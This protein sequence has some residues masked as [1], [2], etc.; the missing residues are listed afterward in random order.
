MLDLEVIDDR[1]AAITALDPTR[2]RILGRLVEPGSATTVARDLGLTRQKANY[3]LR[4]LESHG[5]VQLVEERP[6]RGVTERIVQSTARAYLIAPDALGA[7]VGDPSRVDL[8]SSRYLL[9]LAA[10]LV[11]EVLELARGAERAG[12]PLATLAIDTDVRFR[13]AADRAA[14]TEELA[15][16][17]AGL[18]A[19][20]HD[21]AAPRGRWHRVVVAS[22]P[23]PNPIP[24]THARRSKDEGAP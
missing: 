4:A 15:G 3:H 23:N 13:N 10:R 8:L 2:A 7:E 5:L 17:V 18:A 9:A 14:F 24:H 16:A 19:R 1:G 21:E 22:H 11:K 20:Y 12:K 6:R